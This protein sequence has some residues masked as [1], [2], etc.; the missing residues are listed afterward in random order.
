[1]VTEKAKRRSWGFFRW[2]WRFTYL[3][4]LGVLGYTGYNIYQGK[5]PPDQEPPD[6]NKKTLVILG[7]QLMSEPLARN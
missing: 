6:P 4:A 1:M 5:Y 7:M 3:S 2:T